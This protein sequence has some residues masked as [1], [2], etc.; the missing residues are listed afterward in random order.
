VSRRTA[1]VLSVVALLVF[2]AFLFV[3]RAIPRDVW[4]SASR[5]SPRSGLARRRTAPPK[6]VDSE[7]ARVVAGYSGH[8][9]G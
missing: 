5:S 6:S 8:A 2:S 4:S 7:Q 3:A 1:A 9:G